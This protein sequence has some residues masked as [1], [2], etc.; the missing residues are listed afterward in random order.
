MSDF[1][2]RNTHLTTIWGQI[3]N[4]GL[5]SYQ[6]HSLFNY[7]KHCPTLL[8]ASPDFDH[9]FT[10]VSLRKHMILVSFICLLR[11]IQ[12][13]SGALT[14][15]YRFYLSMLFCMFYFSTE[16]GSSAILGFVVNLS[17]LKIFLC[18][19]LLANLVS[20]AVISLLICFLCICFINTYISWY[21]CIYI[22]I[23]MFP[24]LLWIC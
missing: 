13:K 14:L 24:V 18:Y 11:S 9:G 23:Y 10:R 4:L 21:K 1:L 3:H 5:L 22:Y 16:R 12:M 15:V 8:P 17:H 2:G 6:C 7:P 19:G 20:N